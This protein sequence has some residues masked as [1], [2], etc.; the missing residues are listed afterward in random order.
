M[1]GRE[2]G[3]RRAAGPLLLDFYTGWCVQCRMQQK[4]L[5]EALAQSGAHVILDRVDADAAPELAGKYAVMQV[6]TLVA[7]RDGCEVARLVG[8]QPVETLVAFLRGLLEAADPAAS[9]GN[10]AAT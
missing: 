1:L 9:R 6:P 3:D 7:I 5:A 8:A 2:P 10:G 4:N